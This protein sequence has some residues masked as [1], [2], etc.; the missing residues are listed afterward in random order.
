MRAAVLHLA[1]AGLGAEFATTSAFTDNASSL[2]VSRKLGY[3]PDGIQRQV[4]QGRP[5]VLQ[6]LRLDRAGW[7]AHQRGP[8]GDHGPGPLPPQLRPPPSLPDWQRAGDEA[9][10]GVAHLARRPRH[11][12]MGRCQSRT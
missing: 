1:F 8:G 7:E 3:L 9:G 10:A 4:S 2:G 12:S 6:L 11:V 5:A